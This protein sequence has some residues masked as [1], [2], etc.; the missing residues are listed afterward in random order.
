MQFASGAERTTPTPSVLER[1]HRLYPGQ[2]DSKQLVA[3]SSTNQPNDQVRNS[4]QKRPSLLVPKSL[5]SAEVRR[6]PSHPD[7][8]PFLP[9][10]EQYALLLLL[11][12]A[13]AGTLTFTLAFTLALALD[14]PEMKQ[15]DAK[16]PWLVSHSC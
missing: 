10:P 16:A 6:R 13:V 3:C 8:S 15:G 7:P 11:P 12:L 14:L 1:P 4:S 9:L 5:G 2:T